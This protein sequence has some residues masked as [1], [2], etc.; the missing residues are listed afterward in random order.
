MLYFIRI[1]FF[2]NYTFF[3]VTIPWRAILPQIP[4]AADLIANFLTNMP[5]FVERITKLIEVKEYEK[6]KVLFYYSYF[7]IAQDENLI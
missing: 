2:K 1:S 6:V 5:K 3:K 7:Y 4:S